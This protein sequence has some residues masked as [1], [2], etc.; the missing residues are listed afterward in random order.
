MQRISESSERAW[1]HPLMGWAL[2]IFSSSWC[3][4]WLFHT[5]TI[6]YAIGACAVGAAVMDALMEDLRAK[7]R[8]AWIILLFGFL[9]V[10]T[11]AID[12]DKRKTTEELT[13]HF[14]SI[15]AQAQ[16]NLKQI[17]ED[18][19]RNFKD[20][21]ANQQH[22]FATMIGQLLRQQKQQALEFNAVLTR[23]QQ[24]FEHE[25]QL[26]KSL[27]GRLFPASD[28]TPENI[29]PKAQGDSVLL[30]LGEAADQNTILVTHFPR[31][32]VAIQNVGPVIT[33]DRASDGSIGVAMDI[34][35]K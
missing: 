2:F 31:T 7:A 6:G 25:Q 32:V 13:N 19:N 28:P 1:K 15:S 9:W 14:A 23:Q 12:E 27:N 4:W 20:V 5:P 17:L 35:S 24:L 11:K 33:L 29:C 22:N 26:S 18:E 34:R 21:L 10:E 16:T 30:F 8:F 3:L